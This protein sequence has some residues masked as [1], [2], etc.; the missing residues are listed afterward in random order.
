MNSIERL[1]LDYLAKKYSDKIGKIR[2]DIRI[3]DAD[4]FSIFLK[5]QFDNNPISVYI[6]KEQ[7][8]DVWEYVPTINYN[9]KINPAT[10]YRVSFERHIN[11]EEVF[12]EIY[13][14]GLDKY[15]PVDKNCEWE[16]N[17]SFKESNLNDN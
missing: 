16:L 3:N 12:D 1:D 4:Y 8:G 5:G 14:R 15:D 10:L 9:F 7:K 17:N 11:L 6:E 2:F 13:N